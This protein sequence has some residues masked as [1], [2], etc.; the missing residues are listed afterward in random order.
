MFSISQGWNV[1]KQSDK[2]TK[3]HNTLLP[4]HIMKNVRLFQGL[5]IAHLIP[6]SLPSL[7]PLGTSGSSSNPKE[8]AIIACSTFRH[9]ILNKPG[10]FSVFCFSTFHPSPFSICAPSPESSSLPTPSAWAGSIS[11]KSSAEEFSIN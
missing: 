5:N 4:W 10:L 1:K 6:T 7:N 9:C 8:P 3:K 11:R 2:V